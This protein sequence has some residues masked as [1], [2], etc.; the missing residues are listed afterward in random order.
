MQHHHATGCGVCNEEV[1]K[2]NIGRMV[3]NGCFAWR[4]QERHDSCLAT[5]VMKNL[6]QNCSVIPEDRIGN[7]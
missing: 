5:V 2:E 7:V 1:K 6:G 3:G 4:R